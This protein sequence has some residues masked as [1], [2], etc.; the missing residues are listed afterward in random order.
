MKRR[1]AQ[2]KTWGLSRRR[3]GKGIERWVKGGL[4]KEICEVLGWGNL[5]VAQAVQCLESKVF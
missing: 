3:V 2:L 4:R 5:L 1:V